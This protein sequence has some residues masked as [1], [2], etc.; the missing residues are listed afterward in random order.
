M[1]CPTCGK[2]TKILDSMRNPDMQMCKKCGVEFKSNDNEKLQFIRESIY[3]AQKSHDDI[4]RERV[5]EFIM[6][7]GMSA[8]DAETWVL[9]GMKYLVC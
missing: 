9:N 4:M 8:K 7:Y 6:K 1:D 5:S 3:N 2:G